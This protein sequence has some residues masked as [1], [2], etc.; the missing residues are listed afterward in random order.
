MYSA[1]A[2]RRVSFVKHKLTRGTRNFATDALL[3]G[4]KR[5]KREKNAEDLMGHRYTQRERAKRSRVRASWTSSRTSGEDQRWVCCVCSGTVAQLWLLCSWVRGLWRTLE[6]SHVLRDGCGS[7]T[8]R[9]PHARVA[10]VVR[11]ASRAVCGWR[12]CVVL[13]TAAAWSLHPRTVASVL[14]P[15]SVGASS[16]CVA[17]DSV[18]HG[19][20]RAHA[21]VQVCFGDP[22]P[23]SW[24]VRAT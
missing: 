1:G 15:R 2:C 6:H 21:G 3:K 22:G 4:R 8:R 13:W 16:R 19:I 23:P 12:R 9:T 5:K 14:A 10:A 7:P 24:L 17:V 20:P 18:A 11:L